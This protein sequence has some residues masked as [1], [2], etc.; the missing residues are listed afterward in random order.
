MLELYCYQSTAIVFCLDL[1]KNHILK[2]EGRRTLMY[3]NALLSYLAI[4]LSFCFEVFKIRIKCQNWNHMRIYLTNEYFEIYL[5]KPPQ[6][7]IY[8]RNW[9]EELQ[10]CTCSL[11]K[12]CKLVCINAK[13][14]SIQPHILGMS[15]LPVNFSRSVASSRL[16]FR[17]EDLHVNQLMCKQ[18]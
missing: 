12:Q 5:I 6:I 15:F 4:H 10:Y 2:V 1:C 13:N 9:R 18:C 7:I 11:S 16:L 14:S 17:V 3:C 8:F